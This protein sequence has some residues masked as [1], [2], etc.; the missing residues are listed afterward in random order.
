M[1]GK[2][3]SHY[4]ILEK[5]GEGGMGVVYKAEDTKLKRTVAL[6]FLPPELTRDTEAK[7]R[8]LREARAAAALN[9]SNICT[10]YEIDDTE[11][12]WPF[13]A[14]EFIEGNSLKDKIKDERLKIQEVVEIALQIA[15]GL[16][17]AHEYG[18]IHRDMKCDNVMIA[19]KGV[20]KIMDFGLAKLSGRTQVTQE[21]T[22][23]GTISY[24]SPEQA[25][26]EAV[27]QRTDIWSFGVM[28]YEM[29]TGQ[30]PLRGEYDQAVVYSILNEEPE[31]A[32]AL[33]TG[34]PLELERTVNKCL[35]KDRSLRYQ[36][37]DELIVDLKTVQK[38][39]EISNSSS[40]KGK[41]PEL[42]SQPS[43]T[44]KLTRQRSWLLAAT[45][46]LA[47]ILIFGYFWLQ[48]K[49]REAAPERKRI[50]VL[51]FENLGSADDSY[52]SEGVT[53][54]ITSRLA[55]VHTLS[56]ISRNSAL[57]YANTDKSIRKIGKELNVAYILE[58]TVRWAKSFGEMDRVRITP[59]LIRVAD[60]VNVWSDEYD[61]TISDIFT[62]QSDIVLK[63]AEQLAGTLSG[64]EREAV[65]I[66]LTNNLDAYHAYLRGNYLACSPHFTVE[67]WREVEKCYERAVELDPNFALAYAKLAKAHARFIFLWVDISEKRRQKAREAARKALELASQSG[68]VHMAMSYYYLWAQRNPEE[69]L[70]ELRQAEEKKA[71]RTEIMNARAYI[72]EL[73][74]RWDEAVDAFQYAFKLNP[75]DADLPT[76][77]A[78]ANWI[79]RRYKTAMEDANRAIDLAPSASWPY[80]AKIF[81]LW[82][83]KGTTDETRKTLLNVNP[84]HEWAPWIWFWQEAFE[85]NYR[86]A[87]ERLKLS[88]GAWIQLKMW[89]RPKKLLTAFA[90][91]NM[92]KPQLA[93]DCYDSA[94]VM[95]EAEVLRW[96]DD[97]RY[98]SSLGIAYAALGKKEK[99]IEEGKKALTLLPLSHDAFY[100][101]PYVI[102]MAF[103]Y[104]LI[105]DY[106]TASDQLEY[107]L[108]IP[109][110]FST[111]WLKIDSRW[112]RLRHYPQFRELL[113]KYAEGNS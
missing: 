32:T 48:G 113:E 46:F 37:L 86:K 57:R 59:K 91:E 52:F 31:P 76:E 49:H 63:I 21:G 64:A 97:P 69:A 112:N 92:N 50:V 41:H 80:M 20:A 25:R 13:I 96:P 8:F 81:I 82:S 22:T 75:Q 4:K 58:G 60:D 111:T 109:S 77:L 62:L 5:L 3:I 55:S 84:S 43:T 83:W 66:R 78:L 30:L 68:S 53:E 45:A 39:L 98:H 42:L 1:I 54:E 85:G 105:G 107:L 101:I 61:R 14:M 110:W 16:Q 94:R 15:S 67:N 6:K 73:Q 106:T 2:T 108:S 28:L 103:I 27:D 72:F 71:D 12:G 19:E 47:V 90:Y 17:A 100:G 26:G 38:G 10:I 9:H 70:A 65:E 51:P 88:H 87:I 102:D 95:L 99:A 89:A 24:M 23:L 40:G 36:H 11:D 7:D 56:V 79:M 93:H 29:I 34:V 18:I 35:Q 33:R 104:T 74:G 44:Q